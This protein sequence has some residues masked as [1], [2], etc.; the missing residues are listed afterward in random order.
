[1]E[2]Q[3]IHVEEKFVLELENLQN[4]I[5]A[6]LN[7]DYLVVGPTVRD[8]AII[9]DELT[10]VNDLP[11]G[12]TDKQDAG[13]YRLAKRDDDALFGYTVGQHSWKK[14]LHPATTDLWGAKRKGSGFTLDFGNGEYPKYAFFGVRPCELKAIGIQDKILIDGDYVDINYKSIREN[15]LVLV[16]NCC[17][18]SG[19][20][21]CAS[22]DA[23]PKAEYGFDLAL[24]EIIDQDRHYFLIEVG[25]ENGAMILDDIP[26]NAAGEDD[27][28]VADELLTKAAGD[29]GRSLD[30]VGLKDLFYSSYEHIHWEDIAD[31]CLTCGNCTMVCPTCFCNTIEDSNSLTGD[32]AGRR[33]MWDSCFSVDFAYIHGGSTRVTPRARYR[34]WITHKLA[35]WQDQFGTLGCVGCGRC[36][37]WCPA[38]IDITEEVTTLRGGAVV[39]KTCVPSP[40]RT[41]ET[42][43][44]ILAEHPFVKQLGD[45]YLDI[46]AECSSIARFNPGEF[47][48]RE[49][50]DADRFYLIRHGKVAV[51]T[52]SAE[53]G[54]IIVQ[55][56]GEGDILGWSWLVPPYKWRFDAVAIE[57]TRA[58]AVEARGLRDRC[59]KDPRLCY[60]VNKYA[61]Q[62]I[63][64]RI[65]ATRMQL[66]D[67]YGGNQ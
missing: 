5:D 24:T 56:I 54:T 16:V 11:K 9:Y 47:I 62:I 52:T 40:E 27:V 26:R 8:S 18:P 38:G 6:L 4:L 66:L 25:S 42:L 22:M 50:E 30:T 23:G 53:R 1:M 7:R 46:I 39:C 3:K 28:K 58:I 35:T 43:K 31:R 44:R 37:T 2:S 29:M 36:I 65:E 17:E 45:E 55:T 41:I 51:E 19:T 34:H 49:N 15:A 14:Y 32:V 57:L 33:R 64:Q 10:S 48:I 67:L 21:F 20:C 13:K 61:A 60:L 63:A 59:A 12:W